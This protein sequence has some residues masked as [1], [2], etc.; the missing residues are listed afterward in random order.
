M[1][2]KGVKAYIAS[3]PLWEDIGTPE[4]YS[5][6]SYSVN[7]REAFRCAYPG[8][9]DAFIHKTALKG[10]G[11]DR[12]WFRLSTDTAHSMIMVDHG[13]RET[14][15]MSEV[16]SFIAIGSHLNRKGGSRIKAEMR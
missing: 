2:Q 4:S 14:M 16:D 13:V 12:M 10:D 6:V 1:D 15:A 5:R 9:P 7:S 11:S 3:N 8:K